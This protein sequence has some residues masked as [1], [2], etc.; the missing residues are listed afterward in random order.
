MTQTRRRFISSAAAV[1]GTTTFL[2]FVAHGA[3]HSTDFFTTEKGAITVHPVRHAS[4]VLETPNGTIYCDPVGDVS[5][6]ADFPRADL[7][8]ITHHHG[9][10]YNAE[11]LNGLVGDDTRLIVN[12]TVFDKL[13]DGLKSKSSQIANGESTT[14]KDLKIDA[15][16][17]YNTTEDRKKFHPQGRDNSYVLSF[18]G[19]RVYI[20]GDT[21]DVPEMRALTDIDLA[22]LCMNL[23]FTMDVAAAASAIA[24]FK[25]KF[26]YPYH[27]RGRDDGTQDP[28]EFAKLVGATADVKLHDWY[29]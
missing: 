3:S 4:F 16:A 22:F 21:E 23:P 14:F 24:E 25:P 10:H 9:D 5:A 2:P 17:A 6:Y 11:T 12:P 29:G 27:Y 15:I 1:I 7:I 19:F 28:K 13:P 20:S 18:D 8:L 26:V